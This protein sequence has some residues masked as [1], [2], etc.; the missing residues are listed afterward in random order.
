LAGLLQALAP[1]YST[2]GAEARGATTQG[3]SWLPVHFD[4]REK[5]SSYEQCKMQEERSHEKP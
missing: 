1:R 2:G 4:R 3:F 5:N